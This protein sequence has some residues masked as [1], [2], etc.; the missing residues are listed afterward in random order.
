MAEADIV[1][2]AIECKS[3][4]AESSLNAFNQKLNQSSTLAGE[5]MKNLGLAFGSAS[6]I[7]Y[8]KRAA[9]ASMA[10]NRELYN[11]KSIASELDLSKVR[12]ELLSLD[13]R[14]GS[15]ADNAG[16]LYFAY[17][18]G[19]RGTEKELV[20][21]TGEVGKL[22]QAIVAGQIP[23][24]D[25]VTSIMNAYGKTA[26]DVTEISDMFFQV[27]KQGKTTGSSFA[28]TIG[29]VAGV[30]ANAGV[31][32][33]E[34]GAAAATL[35]TTMPTERA[36]TSLSAL[37]T[38][39]IK[40]T[41]EATKVAQ[42]YGIELNAAALKSKGL[43]GVM[44]ELNSKVGTNTEA[45][46]QIVPS[47]EGMRAAVALAGGQ[48]KMFADNMEIF[49]NKAGSSAEAFAAQAQNLDKQIASLPDT[50]NK[51]SI[52]VGE[53]AKNILTLNGAL[54]PLLASF[55]N[56]DKGTQKLIAD[57]TL[58]A[59]GYVTV[60]GAVAAI[61]TIKTIQLAL[62][63]KATAAT[64]ADTVAT[65]A[66]T[67][68][69]NA[70]NA[71]LAQ[72]IALINQR[73]AALARGR[74]IPV[75]NATLSGLANARTNEE[76]AQ[77][78]FNQHQANRYRQLEATHQMQ[79]YD[80]L[81]RGGT[82]MGTSQRDSGL[83]QAFSGLGNASSNAVKQMNML[84][85]G[86]TKN[87]AI[88]N[89]YFKN[90][91]AHTMK[92]G[93]S[94]P[95][96]TS[97]LAKFGNGLKSVTGLLTGGATGLAGFA[98]ALGNIGLAVAVAQASYQAGKWVYEKSGGFLDAVGDSL[99]SL[100]SNISSADLMKQRFAEEGAA[101]RVE[102]EAAYK[103]EQ[104]AKEQL[105]A[106]KKNEQNAA[107]GTYES[108]LFQMSK[109]NASLPV[110]AWMERNRLEE[111]EKDIAHR[112]KAIARGEKNT[113]YKKLNELLDERNSLKKSIEDKE[114]EMIDS[115]ERLNRLYD[116]QAMRGAAFSTRLSILGIQR[117]QAQ[118]KF[119]EAEE[120]NLKLKDPKKYYEAAKNLDEA[121]QKYLQEQKNFKST[122]DSLYN[123][124]LSLVPKSQKR[125][126]LQN[127]FNEL[128]NKL[129]QTQ[130]EKQ[131]ISY[132]SEMKSINAELESL[133]KNGQDFAKGLQTAFQAV[134]YGTAQAA[135][136][137][138]RRYY[139]SAADEYA[140]QTQENTKYLKQQTGV[141]VNTLK[142]IYDKMPKEGFVAV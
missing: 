2:L 8:M 3:R 72:Q 114:K 121:N 101:K 80:K 109:E 103:Q 142:A 55:N 120:K 122:Q 73:T 127:R 26:S 97:N 133:V 34:L 117:N 5:V 39:F 79:L 126:M 29:S 59:G 46:A 28:N 33:D 45:I 139:K 16:A 66:N 96:T 71:A 137:E 84:S 41:D 135:Q 18:S 132:L 112:Q 134:E 70:Q 116:E 81:S 14:L 82:M 123:L 21:F 53:S 17:S 92:F 19:V 1:T 54:T 102:L 48:Y 107:K 90:L 87:G 131:Q 68:A 50:F 99:V 65:G 100:F 85:S 6:V 105:E 86:I 128:R 58:L 67:T 125:E 20:K 42:K 4:N 32:L 52:Q 74:N 63:A 60:K 13:S 76:Y 11:I 118:D 141:M 110:Q 44:A 37:I 27:V 49:E 138:S 10:F 104:A 64:A 140:K 136:A 83:K 36:I 78:R 93:A 124:Q 115:Q 38:A 47:I 30:A 7:A 35:T 31:S 119:N 77:T 89:Q 88:T 57:L 40:P 9:A 98:S 108:K 106:A 22:S 12:S 75:A 56:M 62:Q 51:I 129:S 94:V 113:D 61:N 43:S 95:M 23:T 111:I 24:M 91:T 130:D 69:L 15:A 25:A